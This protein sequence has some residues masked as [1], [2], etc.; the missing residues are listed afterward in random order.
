MQT[1]PTATPEFLTV[2]QDGE[3]FDLTLDGDSIDPI[4]MVRGN[5]YKNADQ[6]EFKGPK[7]TGTQTKKFKL[8]SVGYQPNA[9][10]VNK[11]LAQ[12]G[13]PALGQW[14]EAFKEKY[15]LP[16][17]KGPIGF[18]GSE[19]AH[20]FREFPHV[21]DEG[22]VWR[23]YFYWFDRVLRAAWRFAVEVK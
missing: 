3:I 11:A 12:H 4:A 16:D 18:T 8:V 10:A 22:G 14:R 2:P 13:A 6:W 5:G 9:D 15:R 1:A 19:W 20:P 23:S 21:A 17:G 7:V